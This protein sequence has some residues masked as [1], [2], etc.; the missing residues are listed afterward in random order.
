MSARR[1]RKSSELSG[2]T[3]FLDTRGLAIASLCLSCIPMEG[4]ASRM[5]H[6]SSQYVS[7]PQS[8]VSPLGDALDRFGLNGLDLPSLKD[9]KPATVWTS[10]LCVVVALLIAEQALWRSRK[11]HL[12]GKQW[13]I[14]RVN[15]GQSPAASSQSSKLT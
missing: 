9:A 2:S 7:A 13:Q 4:Y 14:V 8:T 6:H 10:V 3:F 12:P 1:F 15:K 5:V 11:R